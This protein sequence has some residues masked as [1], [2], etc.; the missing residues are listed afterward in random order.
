MAASKRGRTQL[1]PRSTADRSYPGEPRFTHIKTIVK[2][3]LRT[4]YPDQ[5]TTSDTRLYISSAPLDIDRLANA[6]RAH[7]GVESMQLEEIVW[8]PTGCFSSGFDAS[9]AFVG[10]NEAKREAAHDGHVLGAVATAVARQIVLEFNVEQPT[11]MS[12]NLDSLPCPA[13]DCHHPV[14]S[15]LA[16]SGLESLDAARINSPRI[17]SSDG[18]SV[19][20]L[21]AA[22]RGV[23]FA[24]RLTEKPPAAGSVG[25]C[26]CFGGVSLQNPVTM[27]PA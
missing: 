2:I 19:T 14:H 7:W 4:E 9:F 24:S 26:G 27:Q 10:A 20:F 11:Q 18:D 12:V 21:D 25:M 8:V 6:A 17:I 22:I 15:P 1:R 5:S 16:D 23:N 3:D 13:Q